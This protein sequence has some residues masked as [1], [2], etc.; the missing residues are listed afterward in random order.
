MPKGSS[1]GNPRPIP[2]PRI[3]KLSTVKGWT[4]KAAKGSGRKSH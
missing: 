4:A 3:A 1:T 2:P